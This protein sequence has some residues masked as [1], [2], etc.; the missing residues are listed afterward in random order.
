MPGGQQTARVCGVATVE[1]GMRGSAVY[2]LHSSCCTAHHG[3]LHLRSAS[4]PARSAHAQQ[5]LRSQPRKHRAGRE[6][7]T[8]A[9]TPPSC[10]LPPPRATAPPLPPAGAQQW[11]GRTQ[12]VCVSGGRQASQAPLPVAGATLAWARVRWLRQ[13]PAGLQHPAPSQALPAAHHEPASWT[14]WPPAA[15]HQPREPTLSRCSSASR[16]ASS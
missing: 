8:C 15:A 5:L 10:V 7:P 12:L 11:D 14:I 6:A 4:S 16:S 1:E 2:R 9:R 13:A 3:V